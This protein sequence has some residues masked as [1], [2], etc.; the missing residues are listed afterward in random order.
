VGS[1]GT[2]AVGMRGGRVGLIGPG[3]APRL[4]KLP[5]LSE[6]DGTPSVTAQSVVFATN[7]GFVCAYNLEDSSVLWKTKTRYPL[8][9]EPV[10]ANGRVFLT[11][12]EGRV[13]CLSAYEGKELWSRSL[14]GRATGEPTVFRGTV[15][16]GSQGGTVLSLDA[17]RGK[18]LKRV[19]LD[20]AV[21]TRVFLNQEFVV[22]GTEDGRLHGYQ[23]GTKTPKWSLDVGRAIRDREL[24]ISE[25]RN[26]VFFVGANNTL[27]RANVADGK[28]TVSAKM[29]YR[30]RPDL[31]VFDDRVYVV[32]QEERERKGVRIIY[33][34]L[35]KALDQDTLELVWEFRDGGEF[36]GGVVSSAKRLFL[37]GSKGQV[38]LIR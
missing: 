15:A 4:L 37:T 2:V 27:F 10:V 20:R 23:M 24:S 9:H 18:I 12:R 5:G 8:V 33:Q 16:V 29:K 21:T 19:Q 7:D 34:D 3:Q 14:D 11:D 35:L 28:V 38:Y 1:D 30:I 26:S 13:F 31:P 25:D 22:F 6:V 32:V 36:H 17:Q